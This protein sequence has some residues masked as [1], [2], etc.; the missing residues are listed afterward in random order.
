MTH[1]NTLF[2]CTLSPRYTD[3]D[4][5]R[6]VNNSRI[7][8]LHQE[9][10]M[11]AHIQQFGENAWFSDSVRLRPLRTHTQYLKESWYGK[12][13][14]AQVKI[15]ECGRDSFRVLSELYQNEQLVGTQQAIMGAFEQGQRVALPAHMQEHLQAIATHDLA[16]P[17][18]ASY[19]EQ[20]QHA[21]NFPVRQ[22][23]TPRFSDVDADSQRSEA[24]LGRYMEQ[25]RFGGIRLLDFEG[26]RV[27][28][29]A[30]DISF[31]DFHMGWTPLELASGISRIGNSSFH[32]TGCALHKGDVQVAASSVMVVIDPAIGRP[33]SLPRGLREQLEAWLI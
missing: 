17:D 21:H 30:V 22:Q 31:T 13:M 28:V 14:Q 23:L 19:C 15:I 12:D 18:A 24:A 9:A 26:T 4:S 33:T 1:D 5:W 16:A 3:L 8:Q 6:H 29:A 11:R 2:S 25:A 20:L 32:F 27:M 10:R 7:Y